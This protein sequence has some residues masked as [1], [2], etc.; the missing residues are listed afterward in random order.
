MN[1][2]DFFAIV[3]EIKQSISR[4]LN[5]DK[6]A[7][8]VQDYQKSNST[9]NFPNRIFQNCKS[10]QAKPHIHYYYMLKGYKN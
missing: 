9:E 6:I 10:S 4:N 8:F 1:S 7:T 3:P 2:D 5:E